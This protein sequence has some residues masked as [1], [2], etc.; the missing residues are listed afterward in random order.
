MYLTA[1]NATTTNFSFAITTN[2]YTT[3]QPIAGNFLLSTGVWHQ[4]ALTLNGN[5]GMLY[6]DGNPVGTNAALTLNP[7]ILG[8]TTNDF[9]GRSQWAT[10]PYYNGQF[11]EFRI[12][13]A[14]L[15]PAEVAA[16]CALG[17]GQ[18]LSTNSPL[19]GVASTLSSLTLVWPLASA[20]FTVQSRTNLYMGNWVNVTSPA[21]QIIAGQWQVPLPQP[22]NAV[23]VFYRLVK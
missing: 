17:S 1:Q 8:I 22:S 19:V 23:P 6:L 11:E 20:G 7:V 10:D 4:V 18:L 16:T 21:P 5:S 15:S 12:Y 3:E 2:S 9:L 13:N 14:A